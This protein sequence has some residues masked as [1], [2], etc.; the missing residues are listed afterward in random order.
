M[1]GADVDGE[2]LMEFSEV[3]QASGSPASKAGAGA[4][5]NTA[6]EQ[7]LSLIE[8]LLR[9]PAAPSVLA[10]GVI[11]TLEETL[12]YQYGAILLV[13]MEASQLEPYALSEK[14]YGREFADAFDAYTSTHYLSLD[15]G[16]TGRVAKTGQPVRTGDIHKGSPFDSI[17]ADI[18]SVLC[19][20]VRFENTVLGVM[21]VESPKHDAF[22]VSDQQL[23]ETVAEQL[24]YAIKNAHASSQSGSIAERGVVRGADSVRAHDL[25]PVPAREDFLPLGESTRV[26]APADAPIGEADYRSLVEES[27]AIFYVSERSGKHKLLYVSP[28][29]ENLLGYPQAEWISEGNLWLTSLHPDDRDRVLKALILWQEDDDPSLTLEYRLIGQ[30]SRVHWIWDVARAVRGRQGQEQLL[31]GVMMDVTRRRGMEDVIQR[32]ADDLAQLNAS[33]LVQNEELNAYSHTV[34]HDLQNPLSIL[35][36]YAEMLAKDGV[37]G[38]DES[39]RESVG[40]I[41]ENARRLDSIIK[42]I[43]LLAEV[44][45]L[46]EV[47]IE[48]LEMGSIVSEICRRLSNTFAE[49]EVEIAFPEEWPAAIGYRPWVEEIW[50]NYV[51]NAVKYG[52]DPPILKLGAEEL[53]GD[54][55]RFWVRD[56]GEGIAAEDQKRLFAPFTKL[57]RRRAKGH[58]LGLSIVQRIATKLG[59]QVG[60]ESKLGEG[61]LFWFTLPSVDQLT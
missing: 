40:A 47:D 14:S 18:H 2:E 56:N 23:L 41:L 27:P 11:R 6:E 43:L 20:P 55:V 28:H 46:E 35:V 16:I 30:D 15:T 36:G 3:A 34:A 61:S 44:R 51:N 53:D 22:D 58:G 26:G 54:A 50:F 29:I 9:G 5:G 24:A 60:V 4:V 45:Q 1:I 31:Q 17:R 49:N 12:G 42:E 38:D 39:F 8:Q 57:H 32:Q 52:G 33:L 19:V 7:A 25:D 37:S 59:G 21:A 10:R 48:P 13:D